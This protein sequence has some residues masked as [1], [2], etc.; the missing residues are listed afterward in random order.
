[1]VRRIFNS[2]N[3][4]GEFIR[5]V[6][7]LLGA[8]WLVGYWST[9]DVLGI[10]PVQRATGQGDPSSASGVGAI[11]AETY[12]AHSERGPVRGGK[13][14]IDGFSRIRKEARSRFVRQNNGELKEDLMLSA[15]I[16]KVIT[17]I[18][19]IMELNFQDYQ[20]I[21]TFSGWEI[22][23]IRKI[24]DTLNTKISEDDYAVRFI[25]EMPPH[26][27]FKN[28]WH[29]TLERCT[30]LAG[31]LENNGKKYYVGDIVDFKPYEHHTPING[32]DD[33]LFLFVEFLKKNH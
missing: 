5:Y 27:G 15:K 33:T 31:V 2:K 3:V 14:G 16:N 18:K 28:H 4:M 7:R 21:K 8:Y 20:G 13:N 19:S 12:P 22:G 25:T 11:S 29:D 30:V 10:S 6:Q 9:G 32:G 17:E 24:N 23:E 1:M 26:T